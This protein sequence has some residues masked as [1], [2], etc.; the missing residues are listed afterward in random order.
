MLM[1][2]AEKWT[3]LLQESRIYQ[4]GGRSEP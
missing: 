4:E 1:L 2:L 3:S